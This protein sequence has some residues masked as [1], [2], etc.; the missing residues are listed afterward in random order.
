MPDHIPR[1]IDTYLTLVEA[2]DTA[3]C[4]FALYL[5]EVQRE[6]YHNM[7]FARFYGSPER[8]EVP[9]ASVPEGD[10]HLYFEERLWEH[11]P[12][13]AETQATPLPFTWIELMMRRSHSQAARRVMDLSAAIGVQGGLTMPFHGPGGNWDVVSLS[14]RDKTLLDPDRIT[15]VSMKT[16]AMVQR[17]HT[18]EARKALVRARACGD[19]AHARSDP[20][21]PQHGEAVG[22]IDDPECRALALV[23]IAW[24]RYSAGFLDLNRRVP[25]I[26]GDVLLD[27]FMKRGLIQEEPDDLRFHYVYKPSPVGQNHLRVCPCV[28]QWRDEVLSNYVQV[29]ERP[30]D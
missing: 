14:M 27:R 5:G 21:H 9:Y 15:I 11:D 6:R 10:A 25:E 26:V 17:Y 28:S 23:E 19:E 1:S 30:V 13:L 4:L 8:F 20:H 18:L 3:E 24:K 29:H 12:V 22:V 2:C 16:Y 7:V